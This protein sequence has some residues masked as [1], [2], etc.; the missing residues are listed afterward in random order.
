MDLRYS[1]G[2]NHLLAGDR[3]TTL[4]PSEI[5]ASLI[6]ELWE[7]IAHTSDLLAVIDVLVSRGLTRLPDLAL[8][9]AQGNDFQVLLRGTGRAKANGKWLDSEDR[10]TWREVRVTSALITLSLDGSDTGNPQVPLLGGIVLASA[11]TI[12]LGPTDERCEP[13]VAHQPPQPEAANLAPAGSVIAGISALS[14]GEQDEPS[15]APP[16]SPAQPQGRSDGHSAGVDTGQLDGQPNELHTAVGDDT[17]LE[18]AYDRLFEVT[19]HGSHPDTEALTDASFAGDPSPNLV[20]RPNPESATED[21]GNPVHPSPVPPPHLGGEGSGT[22]EDAP[23]LTV[24]RPPDPPSTHRTASVGPSVMA[25]RCSRDHLNPPGSSVC[26]VCAT[27]IAPQPPSQVPRPSL[28]VLLAIDAPPGSPQ[29]IVLDT[30]LLIGRR[31]SYG[32]VTDPSSRLVTI[33]SP[34]RDISRRHLR[35]TLDGWAVLITDLGSGNGTV[36]QLPGRPERSLREGE[37]LPIIPGTRI[38]IAGVATYHFEVE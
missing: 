31:P 24:V 3:C 5:D 26:R 15:I 22:D 6:A 8:A 16:T 30:D 32:A 34:D 38:T 20:T 17:D 1:R 27:G 28:G 4:L 18:D 37:V 10:A 14:T 12:S 25:L 7:I 33:P 36:A 35:V 9:H 11:V 23:E 21:P 2:T 29:R 13:A 19:Y